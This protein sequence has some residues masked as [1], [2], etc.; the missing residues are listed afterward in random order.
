MS[1]LDVARGAYVRLPP[2]ARNYLGRVLQ[3]VPTS[4][5][6]GKTYRHWRGQIDRARTDTAFV[7]AYRREAL[8]DVLDRAARLSPYYARTIGPIVDGAPE[9][10]LPGS[11]AWLKI[12]VLTRQTVVDNLDGM[13][14]V[15]L[16]DLDRVSTDGSSGEPLVFRLDRNRSP[17]EYAFVHD[18]WARSGFT[19]TDWR[20]VFRGLDLGKGETRDM[21]IEPALKEL[22]L[23]V[24][25]LNDES[26]A[27]YLAAIR[28]RNIEFIY[29]YPSAIAIFCDFLERTGAAPLRQIRGVLPISERI[30]PHQRTL[31]TRAF[32]RAVI[33]PFYGMSE[34]VAFAIERPD[35]PETYEFNPLYGYTELLDEHDQPVTTPGHVGRVVSTGLLFR[36]MPLIRYDTRDEAELVE[37]PTEANGYRLVLKNLSPRRDSEYVVG[38][39]GTLIPFC[40]LCVPVDNQNRVREVQFYQDTPGEVELRVVVAD[41]HPPDLSDYLERMAQRSGSDLTLNLQLVDRLPMTNRGKRKFIDQRLP[42]SL[43]HEAP[44][45]QIVIPPEKLKDPS[46]A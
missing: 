22:R 28:E 14:T 20:A 27:R 45:E 30:Y 3:F 16:R 12:P 6:F 10:A 29:G 25:H 31:M 26:M 19:A 43:L 32:D 8:I 33:V 39:S 36:G 37:L 2:S 13:S 46:F 9:Q 23:S 1:V 41:G 17:I 44:G 7:K 35:E 15:P 40:G 11:E 38:R 5:K 18:A 4:L 24:F 34:K 21:E 42:L